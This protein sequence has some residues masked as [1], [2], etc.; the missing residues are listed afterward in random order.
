MSYQAVKSM[1][2]TRMHFSK[3]KKPIW[4]IF[5]WFQLYDILLK[6]NY[7]DSKKIRGWQGLGGGRD[8]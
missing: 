2:E 4:K 8:E 3:W 1:E 5:I 6:A 7:G